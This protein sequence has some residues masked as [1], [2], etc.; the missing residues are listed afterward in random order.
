MSGRTKRML[1]A[2]FTILGLL[3]ALAAAI[4]AWYFSPQ[5][6]W[7]ELS[8]F[9]VFYCLLPLNVLWHELGHIFFGFACNMKFVSLKLGRIVFTRANKK[10]KCGFSASNNAAGEYV[11][12][13]RSTKQIR[14]RFLL[15]TLGGAVFNFVYAVPFLVLFF[16]GPSHPALLFFE[17]FVPLSLLEGIS[18]LVPVEL[19]AGK[20]DGLVA[21]GLIKRRPEEE[22][23]L[24]VLRAQGIL[25]KKT[26]SDIPHTLLFDVPV[27]REDLPALHALLFLR[28]QYLFWENREDEAR[29]A[30]ENAES[31]GDISDEEWEEFERYRG[32]FEGEFTKEDSPMYGVR[33]LENRLAGNREA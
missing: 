14:M 24:C 8:L 4:L 5:R 22:I 18:A 26:F 1:Y 20:T 7:L 10:L 27:V 9:I 17:M 2:F 16:F 13:P 15:T 29:A 33:M 6:T 3:A 32:Y 19:S 11:F 23:A 21:I 25:Y 28:M 31:I 30:L 12:F